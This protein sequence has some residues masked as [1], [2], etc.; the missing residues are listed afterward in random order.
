MRGAVA[1]LAPEE[2]DKL[3]AVPPERLQL[4]PDAIVMGEFPVARGGG[5]LPPA[6][7]YAS[8]LNPRE[9]VVKPFE[10]MFR[11]DEARSLKDEHLCPER[12]SP[13][14]APSSRHQHLR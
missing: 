8:S 7:E 4:W 13:R 6:F 12:R 3:T 14:A 5:E 9:P 2:K 11:A 10:G 1:N